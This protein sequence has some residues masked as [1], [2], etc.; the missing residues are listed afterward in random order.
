M[1]Q[2]TRK[3]LLLLILLPLLSFSQIS[4]TKIFPFDTV[5][6]DPLKAH[7]YTLD[8]GLK[9]Y[10][11]VYK[12]EPRF[13]SMIG[14]KAGSKNDPADHTGLA[15]YLEHMLFKGTDHY[16]SLDYSK[17]APLLD[18]IVNLY[19]AYGQTKDS[20]KRVAIYH[21]IDSVSGVAATFAI[22]NEF[23]KMMASLGVSGVNA[24]TSVEQT[25]YVNNVPS[26]QFE[27]FFTVEA[28][29]FRKPVMR[30]FHTELEAVYEE[31]NRALD[32]D[33]RKVYEALLGG[34]F[35]KHQYGTQTTIGTVEHLKSPS[36][37]EIKNF[38]NTYYVPNNM[39]ISLSGD[40]DPDN[41]IRVIDEKFGKLPSKPVPTFVV[42][43]ERF[44]KQPIVKEVLG[45]DAESVTLGFRF[46]GANSQDADM[47]TV[48][49]YILSNGQA[50]LLDLNLNNSQKVLT[51]GSSTNIMKDYSVHVISGR[52][53]DGQKLE[54]VRDLLLGQIMEIKLGNFPD[55]MI[56]AVVNNLKKEQATSYENNNA[57][58]SAMLST[59]V[60]GVNYKDEVNK[61]DRISKINKQQVIDFVRTWYGEGYVIVYKRTG[62]DESVVKVVKPAIT[63]VKM[64]R[65][66]QSDFVRNL[67]DHKAPSI[68]PVFIDFNKSIKTS[69]IKNSIPVYMV[70]NIE[71][72]LFSL[73]YVFEMGS[74]NNKKLSLA[75]EYLK[76]LGTTKLTSTKLQEEFYK[77]GCS[78]NAGASEDESSISLDGI[79][80]NFVP[81]L[82][83]LE[84]LLANMKAD[85]A[86]LSN[87]KDDIMKRRE[88][89]KLNKNIILGAMQSYAK[90]GAKSAQTNIL[91]ESELNATSATELV[92]LLKG[93]TGYQH[94]VDYYGP[95]DS[96]TIT[97]T[98]NKTH[99]AAATLKPIPAPI[100]FVELKTD[101]S[102]VFVVNYD[103]KQAEVVFL[104]QGM[105]YDKSQLA[106]INLY[107]R[108]FGGGMSSPIFQTLRESKALA[109]SVSS[110][111]SAPNILEKSF[112][113]FAYIGSQVDKLPEAAAGMME[114]LKEFPMSEKGFENAKDGALQQVQTERITKDDLLAMYHRNKKLG[115]NYDIRKEVYS[116]IPTLTLSDIK[117]FQ[118][119]F[120]KP[121]NYHI[122][123]LGNHDK[124]DMKSLQKYGTVTE[125]GLSDIFGY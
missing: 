86:A 19:Q 95:A 78:F 89:A 110:R 20:S 111:Y 69:K 23:D 41:A 50:G 30:L 107:N 104:A 72:N 64:N 21:Q 97:N 65:E 39:V 2:Y 54:E 93:L 1:Y 26:N 112:Y 85:T 58:A 124:L 103:M 61:I 84:D 14:V 31:K 71:N 125:L 66:M 94:Y 10:L 100:K 47:L 13:Q 121:L 62:K 75:L 29:R 7:I 122:V 120:I 5:P 37:I 87:L 96:L 44:L 9:V 52:P 115:L 34:I 17:E 101:T 119:Q 114:L 98:L 91:S 63:P 8:N 32:N 88:N 60:D 43:E 25:V 79:H 76:Y 106:K 51:S 116:Q 16:G 12:D 3:F 4:K 83:L 45:P 92:S 48:V 46:K 36:L 102:K 82:L 38:F 99:K 113:N 40:F 33:S 59:E 55:W 56:S 90:Y 118:E 68:D 108:Y 73:D 49:D 6:G 70:K 80:E 22:P 35:E 28:E 27:N 105:H 77:L 57:R 123:V 24:F 11:S 42:P 15:H 74:N 67:A 117:K 81:A 18:S 53:R 109:Y